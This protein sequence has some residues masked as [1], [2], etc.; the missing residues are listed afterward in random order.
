M[1]MTGTA[2]AQYHL[3]QSCVFLNMFPVNKPEV[4]IAQAQNKFDAQGKLT[5]EPTRKF[6][7]DLMTALA[8][9]TRRM[10]G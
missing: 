3:R 4:F 7:A 8:A 6:I 9:W 10:K 2:R 5:D 1:G